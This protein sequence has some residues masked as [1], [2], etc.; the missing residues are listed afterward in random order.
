VNRFPPLY[1]ENYPSDEDIRREEEH[2]EDQR[3][4]EIQDAV[5]EDPG[6]YI[7]FD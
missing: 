2:L 3:D 7:P 4:I 1:Y 6:D 5:Y